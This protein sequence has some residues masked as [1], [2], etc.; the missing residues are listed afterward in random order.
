V[1]GRADR[2]VATELSHLAAEGGNAVS[3]AC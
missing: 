1:A 3:D 2:W